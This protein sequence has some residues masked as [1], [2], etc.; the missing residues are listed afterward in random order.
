MSKNSLEHQLFLVEAQLKVASAALLAA[1]TATMVDSCTQLQSLSIHLLQM[2]QALG[3]RHADVLCLSARMDAVAQG[4]PQV[5]E[6]LLRRMAYVERALEMVV[7][8][9]QKAGY[10]DIQSPYGNTVRQSGQFKVLA[11]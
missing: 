1:S 11:A 5:R 10:A 4:L 2:T 9:G 3:P 7:P 6:G 8:Q